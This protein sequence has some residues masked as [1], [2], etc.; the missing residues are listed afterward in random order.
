MT[1]SATITLTL[2]KGRVKPN[3]YVFE[4]RTTCVLGRSAD[5]SPRLPTTPTTG[6]SPATTA[7]STSTRRTSASA[8]SAASRAQAAAR[9]AHGG[10]ADLKAIRGYSVIRELGRGGMGAVYLARHEA[11]SV[12]VALKV[13]LPKVAANETARA[14]FLREVA[15][16][17]ALKHPQIATL[18]DAGFA[19]GTFYLTTEFCTGGSLDRLVAERGGRLPVEEAVPIAVQA[20]KGLEH[21]HAQ[22]IVHRDLSP[23][24]ILLHGDTD[25]ATTAKIAD[26]GIGR[27]LTRRA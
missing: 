27:P 11:T 1:L 14:R 15:L 26:F 12:E 17:R 25:G 8:T 2:V 7:C 22:G 3:A 4:E 13:M 20:L 18:H 6:P 10:R 19:N 5:C 16:T 24:D 9:P 21:A 23:S